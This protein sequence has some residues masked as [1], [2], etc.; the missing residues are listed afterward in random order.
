[1]LIVNTLTYQEIIEKVADIKKSKS[2]IYSNY[3]PLV[4][5]SGDTKFKGYI[6]TSTVMYIND[7]NIVHRI[8]FFSSDRNEL[9][10]ILKSC[11][12]GFG[13]DIPSTAKTIEDDYLIEAGFHKVAI[14]QRLLF[15]DGTMQDEDLMRNDKYR[16]VYQDRNDDIVE[17]AT[18]RDAEEIFM[19]L[20]DVFDPYID[21]LP[22]KEELLEEFIK[23]KGML[24]YRPDDKILALAGFLINGKRMFWRYAINNSGDYK[25][26]S[27]LVV[28]SRDI[29]LEK[30]IKLMY[31]FL[32]LSEKREKTRKYYER[33][34]TGLDDFYNHVYVNINNKTSSNG[35]GQSLKEITTESEVEN[36][37]STLKTDIKNCIY[38]Y[39]DL[40]KYG[41]NNPNMK[42]WWK[43]N[44]D[45]LIMTVMKYHNSF[46]IYSNQ[47]FC[48]VD[49]LIGLIQKYSPERISGNEQII[50]QLE[51]LLMGEYESEYGVIFCHEKTPVDEKIAENDIGCILAQIDD[52]PEIVELLLTEEPFKSQYSKEELT[53]QMTERYQTGMGRSM[54][55]KNGD[56][57]VAH[58]GSFA[59]TNELAML[60]GAVI[61]EEYRDTNYYRGLNDVFLD[62]ICRQEQKDAY[63]SSVNKRHIKYFTKVDGSGTTYGKLVKFNA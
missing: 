23:P 39:I 54:I 13:L 56:V 45:G 50:K 26:M 18:E 35:N 36:L 31:G 9:I 60:S 22:T 5:I 24:I 3:F 28:R 42:V 38:I 14:L 21:H 37:L 16:A 7:K 12:E 43:K 2:R 27:A 61:R 41:L 34:D 15:H 40:K 19:I 30:K 44:H 8:V 20:Q 10:H 58:T 55:I 33:R 17:Y 53:A 32:E 25:V 11:P 29:A 52:I 1:M 48:E 46:Q 51:P 57:I 47:V 63:Y 62:L 6:G 4:G 59:E 49:E